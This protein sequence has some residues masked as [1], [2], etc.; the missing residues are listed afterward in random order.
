M[1]LSNAQQQKVVDELN[2]YR[3]RMQENDSQNDAIK[4]KIQ[5]LVQ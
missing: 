4:R 2:E 3:R 5:G 1:R